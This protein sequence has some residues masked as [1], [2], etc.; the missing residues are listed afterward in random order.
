MV[1]GVGAVPPNNEVLFAPKSKEKG[2]ADYVLWDRNKYYWGEAPN[3]T[4]WG[5]L[6]P[7][8]T[9]KYESAEILSYLINW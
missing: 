6:K 5:N 3:H 4:G 8:S 7:E 9:L 2:I 1:E